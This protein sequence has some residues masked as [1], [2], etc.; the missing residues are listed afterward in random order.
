MT[1]S[2]SKKVS[3]YLLGLQKDVDKQ[4]LSYFLRYFA[5]ALVIVIAIDS[6]KEDDQHCEFF[7]S[8]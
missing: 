5:L 4:Y 1:H 3:M 6:K 7:L 2:I 8:V